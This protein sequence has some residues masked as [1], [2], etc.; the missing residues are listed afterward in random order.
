MNSDKNTEPMTRMFLNLVMKHI[1]MIVFFCITFNVILVSGKVTKHF[2]QILF[3]GYHSKLLQSVLSL[4]HL[5]THPHTQRLYIIVYFFLI[6]FLQ[7]PLSVTKSTRFQLI[8]TTNLETKPKLA[9]HTVI[10]T[11]IKSSGTNN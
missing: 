9:V 7:V 3:T 10:K 2:F 6:L 5:F 8:C 4:S 11:T 1:K